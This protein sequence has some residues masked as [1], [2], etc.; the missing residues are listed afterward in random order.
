MREIRV[1]LGAIRAN[2][3]KLKSITSGKVMAVVKANAYGHG[4][5]EVAK[6]LEQVGVDALGVA[7]L[8][9]AL[10]LRKAG[11]SSRLMCWIL[12]PEADLS[13]AKEHDIELGVSTFDQ[14]ERLEPGTKIH[15]KVDTGLGRN[16][17]SPLDWERLFS[18]LAGTEVQGIFSHLSNTSVSD[19]LKQK[20]SFEKALAKAAEHCVRIVERHLAASAA[21]ISYP[22]FH[23]DMIRTGIAIY[24]LNPFEDKELDMGLVPAMRVSA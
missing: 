17:F 8:S 19:D 13:V 16:G 14:L 20:S 15:I 21:A 22:D 3:Q 11:V 5:L 18:A 23:Y 1:D 24:G 6:A 2:Y 12:D 10:E 7:D 4:M 9:E